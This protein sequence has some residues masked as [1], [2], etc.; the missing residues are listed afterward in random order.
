MPLKP[1]RSGQFG[2]NGTRNES[3]D[4][5]SKAFENVMNAIRQ[6]TTDDTTKFSHEDQ[7]F[8]S[9]FK[10]IFRG[11]FNRLDGVSDDLFLRH[12]EDTLSKA[13]LESMRLNARRF[14]GTSF[15]RKPREKT[16]TENEENIRIVTDYLEQDHVSLSGNRERDM[17]TVNGED[18]LRRCLLVTLE[19]AYQGLYDERYDQRDPDIPFS[20]SS[21]RKIFNEHCP[22]IVEPSAKM[23]EE[24]CC[25]YCYTAEGWFD[26]ARNSTVYNLGDKTLTEFLRVGF[27]ATPTLECYYHTCDICGKGKRRLRILENLRKRQEITSKEEL[28]DVRFEL[29]TFRRNQRHTDIMEFWQ[30]EQALAT[31]LDQ[32]LKSSGSG[33]SPATHFFCIKFANRDYLEFLKNLPANHAVIWLDHANG[34][35][36][37]WIQ[38]FNF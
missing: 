30:F 28:K 32:S 12:R 9:G 36:K 18:K 27:C 3:D 4:G 10:A 34:V 35:P 8:I 7:K 33:P 38:I 24:S 14:E 29:K 21:F 1:R 20:M 11:N 19:E 23:I 22:H 6:F 2:K 25:H 31:Y 37:G 13:E 15:N 5:E 17:I 26:A 16:V